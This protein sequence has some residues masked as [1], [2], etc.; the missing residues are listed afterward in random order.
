MNIPQ[1]VDSFGPHASTDFCI[2]NVWW[3][4]MHLCVCMHV[5]VCAHARVC[6]CVCECVSV[7]DCGLH[8]SCFKRIAVE[9]QDGAVSVLLGPTATPMSLSHHFPPSFTMYLYP[10]A[11]RGTLQFHFLTVSRIPGQKDSVQLELCTLT[12]TYASQL[13]VEGSYIRVQIMDN[14]GLPWSRPHWGVPKE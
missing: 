14:Q 11:V 1:H 9:I 8:T 3:S 12:K 6:V 5:C 4:H 2:V 10:A 13:P 7:E